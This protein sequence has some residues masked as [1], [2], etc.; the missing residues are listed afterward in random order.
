MKNNDY[1]LSRV[2]YFDE[3]SVTDY[4]QIINNGNMTSFTELL[5]STETEAS[6]GATAKASV[7]GNSVIKTLFKSL[8][9][10]DYKFEVNANASFEKARNKLVRN[11]IEN[12]LL[13]DFIEAVKEDKGSIEVLKNFDIYPLYNSFAYINLAAPYFKIMVPD[14][15]QRIDDN[16]SLDISGVE[17]VIHKGKGYYE[18]IGET[19]DNSSKVVFRFNNDAFRNNYTMADIIKMDLV[20]FAVKVGRIAQGKLNMTQE[21]EFGSKVIEERVRITG[22]QKSKSES[23]EKLPI[24]D[25]MLAGI[26]V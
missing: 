20:L 11:I 19:N 18:L 17:E 24:Y 3:G 15:P 16:F 14:K 22:S 6:G 26:G 1:Q 7:G 12:T 21:F 4:L 9:G 25:V 13:S 10:V 23:V 5:K 2:V 8:I